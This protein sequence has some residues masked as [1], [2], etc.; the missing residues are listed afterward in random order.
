MPYSAVSKPTD[1]CGSLFFTGR[2]IRSGR[3][4]NPGR[5]EKIKPL[6]QFRLKLTVKAGLYLFMKKEGQR[7]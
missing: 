1:A 2:T 5:S 7:Q 3:S 6:R 4:G